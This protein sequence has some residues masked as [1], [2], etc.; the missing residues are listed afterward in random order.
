[1]M[2]FPSQVVIGRKGGIRALTRMACFLPSATPGP[3]LRRQDRYNNRVI[4]SW[5]ACRNSSAVAAAQRNV[6]RGLV[7]MRLG[8]PRVLARA[9][10]PL[11]LQGTA[12]Q[13]H[14]ASGR[15]CTRDQWRQMAGPSMKP[16]SDDA[17]FHGRCSTDVS[18]PLRPTPFSIAIGDAPLEEFQSVSSNVQMAYVNEPGPSLRYHSVSASPAELAIGR[19]TSCRLHRGPRRPAAVGQLRV[20]ARI[21]RDVPRFDAPPSQPPVLPLNPVK[22]PSPRALRLGSLSQRE[23]AASCFPS[24]ASV[25]G[26][27]SRIPN[28]RYLEGLVLGTVNLVVLPIASR[29]SYCLYEASHGLDTRRA[30]VFGTCWY[31]VWQRGILSTLQPC[32]CTSQTSFRQAQGLAA[33]SPPELSRF[34]PPQLLPSTQHPDKLHRH[35]PPRRRR[36]APGAIEVAWPHCG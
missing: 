13:R 23:P 36:T 22:R 27:A 15:P 34:T 29:G 10:L 32:K 24:T 12:P 2:P 17:Q 30:S 25:R 33:N 28:L 20:A 11:F 9:N 6:G 26:F 21:R 4:P 31:L 16:S 7:T 1:M 8:S 19:W 5:L 14:C 3:A 18:S 35:V